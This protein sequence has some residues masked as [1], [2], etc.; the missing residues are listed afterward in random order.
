MTA[1]QIDMK[2]WVLGQVKDELDKLEKA[3]YCGN[4]SFKVNMFQGGISNI[5]VDTNESKRVLNGLNLILKKEG[6]NG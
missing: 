3:K 4:V 5:N 1:Q 2:E 6:N